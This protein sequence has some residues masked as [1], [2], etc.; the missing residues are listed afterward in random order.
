MNF[1]LL[2]YI[3]FCL[4]FMHLAACTP[5]QS[6]LDLNDVLRFDAT[7]ADQ[8]LFLQFRVS[9]GK[10][11]GQEEVGLVS[12]VA[13]NG[14]LKPFRAPVESPY[15]IEVVP[16]YSVSA[17]E[18]A[19]VYQHPLFQEVEV[20]DP[21]GVITRKK[22]YEKEGAFTMRMQADHN[23]EKLDIYSVT[24]ERGKIKIYTLKLKR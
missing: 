20:H 13:G 24:P 5:R 3:T 9:F 12:A 10:K 18:T 23:I 15:K 2:F 7:V 8:I 11:G 6:A 22:N 19:M 14:K 4:L 1:K 17:L 16:R 21:S